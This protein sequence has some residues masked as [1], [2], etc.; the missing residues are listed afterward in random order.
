MRWM[1]LVLVCA[2]TTGTLTLTGCGATKEWI[3]DKA[4]DIAVKTVDSQIT[5]L[6]E[7][8]IAPKFAEIE[9]NLGQKIDKDDD[10]LWSDDEIKSAAAAQAKKT[11]DEVKT[12]LLEESDKS[13]TEKLKELP[14]KSDQLMMLLYLVGAWILAKLGIKVGPKGLQTLRERLERKKAAQEVN[15]N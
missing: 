3:I 15:L 6:N 2:M 12:L 9:Q 4:K 14:N 11:F 1:G 7:R 8:V 5:K 13:L 10:G